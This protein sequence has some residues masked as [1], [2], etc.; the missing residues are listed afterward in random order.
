MSDVKY[1]YVTEKAMNDMD[2]RNTLQFIVASDAAKPG[3]R[4]EV[5]ERFD[6]AITNV[7]TQVTPQGEKKATVTLSE[8]DDAQDV[9]SRIGV[10]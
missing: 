4:E 10:F 3:I 9:A 1:P 2:Y 7:R 6:V 8:D 5:E